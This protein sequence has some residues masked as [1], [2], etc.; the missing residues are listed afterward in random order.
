MS[1]YQPAAGWILVRPEEVA[2]QTPSGI[3]KPT[4]AL[5]K[6]RAIG[7][8]NAPSFNVLAVGFGA[9]F[10][11]GTP[12]VKYPAIGAKVFIL[13]KP[14]SIVVVNKKTLFVHMDAVVGSLLTR[15]EEN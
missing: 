6:E 14:M 5:E 12:E 8:E 7:A 13:N 9:D 15:G 3:I 11:L 10:G 1:N 2:E 4:T